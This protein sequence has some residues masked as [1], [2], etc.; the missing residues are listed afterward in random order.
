MESVLVKVLPVIILIAL[1]Y[2]IRRKKLL[3]NEEMGGL[4]KLVIK[5]ALPVLLFHIFV[6]MDLKFEYIGVVSVMITFCV[7]LF[8]IGI[9][10]RKFKPSIGKGFPYILPGFAFGLM[11]LAL[12]QTAFPDLPVSDYSVFG[13]GHELFIWMILLTVMQVD[14]KADAFSPKKLLEVFKSPLVLS[15]LLGIGLNILGVKEIIDNNGILSSF[16]A[17]VPL[18]TSIGTPVI[19]I[20]CGFELAFD[21][22]HIKQSV[23]YLV[24]RRVIVYVLGALFV[25]LIYPLVTTVD[26][27]FV[28]NWFMLLMISP[29]LSMGMLVGTYGE[30]SDA[31]II[32]NTVVMDTLLSIVTYIV[33]VVLVIN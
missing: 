5:I 23:I 13:M 22:E 20:Y 11:G 27:Q 29:P 28:I 25:W 1:G 15:V 14:L 8:V 10:I 2:F 33:I 21:G 16:Y 3:T 7:T 17:V 12:Y 9:L 26:R 4:K 30:E 32:N 6:D 31:E 24:L 18:L 19:L